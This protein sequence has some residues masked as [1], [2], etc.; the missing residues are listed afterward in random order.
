MPSTKDKVNSHG[1]FALFKGAP[2]TAKSGAAY[3]FPNPFVFD[4]D[5]KMPTVAIKHFPDKEFNW[6]CFDDVFQISSF[7]K[8]WMEGK[9]CPYETL[10]VDT[11]TSLSTLCLRSVDKTKGTDVIKQMQTLVGTNKTVEV[12]GYDY[13]N[14]EANFF[15]RYFMDNLKILWAR[16]GNPKHVIVIAHEITVESAPDIRTGLVKTTK[17]IVTAGRKV[18]AFIPSRFDEEYVFKIE[19]PPFGADP[20]EKNKRICITSNKEDARTA[21]NFPE[22]IDFTN[23]SLYDILNDTAHW[24]SIGSVDTDTLTN[25]LTTVK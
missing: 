20:K 13:Y 3:S 19:L 17:S 18:A 14:A 25:Q 10:I 6:E 23:K 21:Y 9:S 5:R 12:M 15:E 4:F 2:N 7:L 16:E 11:V 1:L 24:S 8:P 22:V